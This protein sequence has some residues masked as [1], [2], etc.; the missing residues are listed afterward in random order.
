MARR[1]ARHVLVEHAVLPEAQWSGPVCWVCCEMG[2]GCAVK[3]CRYSSSGRCERGGVASR[4]YREVGGGRYSVARRTAT[5]AGTQIGVSALC[6]ALK[7]PNPYP[8]SFRTNPHQP[9]N[10]AT[11]ETSPRPTHP[12]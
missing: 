1:Y 6:A 2:M 10:P 5:A 12:H 11:P 8:P 4:W 9:Q 7:N 3:P